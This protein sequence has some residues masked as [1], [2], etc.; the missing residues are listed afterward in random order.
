MSKRIDLTGQQFDRLKVIEYAGSNKAGKA[1]WKCQC[2]CKKIIVALGV[3]L[4]RGHTTSCGCKRHGEHNKKAK[5]HG[6]RYTRLYRIWHGMKNRTNN[7]NADCYKDYGGRGIEVCKEWENSFADFR[8]WALDNGYEE[9]LTIDRIDNDGNYEPKNCRWVT[10]KENDRNKRN[11]KTVEYNG[12]KRTIAEWAERYCI[13]YSTL[14]T[15]LRK[16]MTIEKALETPVKKKKNY[17]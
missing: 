2:Q 13:S 1:Q 3:D 9:G 4:I 10:Q 5:K 12:E 17:P 14:K 6:G 8:N 11:N 16:G 7:K 15:R